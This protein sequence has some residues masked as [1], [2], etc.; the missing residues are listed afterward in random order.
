VLKA[1]P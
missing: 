1:T